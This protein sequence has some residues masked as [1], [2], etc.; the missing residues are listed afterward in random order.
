[1]SDPLQ[2]LKDLPQLFTKANQLLGMPCPGWLVTTHRYDVM[3]LCIDMMLCYYVQILCNGTIYRYDIMLL[4]IYL[5]DVMLLYLARC[6]VATHRY[7]VM[8]LYIDM[9]YYYIQIC[10]QVA[11][12]ILCH[13][14]I[15]KYEVMLLYIDMMSCYYIQA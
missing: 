15:Y 12:Y 4:Y 5:Y 10:Y 2:C 6:H 9:L 11:I 13:V 8:L 3:V 1:M 14:T 7:D